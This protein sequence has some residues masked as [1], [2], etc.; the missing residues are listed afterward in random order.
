[1]REVAGET[2]RLINEEIE[3]ADKKIHMY[4]GMPGFVFEAA[5][6]AGGEAMAQEAWF[7]SR[8]RRLGNCSSIEV[9]FPD[10]QYL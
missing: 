1:M 7:C 8:I 2:V 6:E 5:Q 10:E 9:L 3:Q 4:G